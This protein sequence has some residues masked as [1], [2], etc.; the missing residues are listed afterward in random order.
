[1]T[2]RNINLVFRWLYFK[3]TKYKDEIK[4]QEVIQAE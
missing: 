4:V 1:M 3:S 2:H